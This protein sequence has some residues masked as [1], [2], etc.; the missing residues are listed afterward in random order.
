[1]MMQMLQAAGV[2]IRADHKRA[3]DENNPRGYLEL[4]E[5]KGI[6]K[7][8]QW[9]VEA[10]GHALKVIAQLVPFLPPRLH[11]KFI[12]MER[13]LDEVLKSQAS[14]LDRLGAV[15]AAANTETLSGI[16]AKQLGQAK[17]MVQKFSGAEMITVAFR[18]TI[19][20]PAEVARSVAEFLGLPDL[21]EAAMTDAVDGQL[22][23]SRTGS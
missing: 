14:M 18:D 10:K 23:R 8:S 3:A 9:V 16:Y 4:E 12:F 11:Y 17:A 19:E 20:H 13:E 21:D 6:A 22:Y 2:P 15:P 7:D 5:V 1:M